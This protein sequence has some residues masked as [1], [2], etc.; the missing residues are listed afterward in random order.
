[1]NILRSKDVPTACSALE[2]KN[3]AGAKPSWIESENWE[4]N[5]EKTLQ[6]EKDGGRNGAS[7]MHEDCRTREVKLE[8]R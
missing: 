7:I 2:V 3:V 5:V 6:D 1:M 4:K 8:K